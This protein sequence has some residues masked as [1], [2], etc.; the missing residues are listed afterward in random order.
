MTN[1]AS[2]F[3]HSEPILTYLG[4]LAGVIGLI[5]FGYFE[6][7]LYGDPRVGVVTWAIAGLIYAGGIVAVATDI[8]FHTLIRISAVL[9]CIA[10]VPQILKVLARVYA[11]AIKN[12]TQRGEKNPNGQ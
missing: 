11:Y 10:I 3:S 2:L 7:R 6:M 1:A 4:A 12:G 9:A 5:L 8:G